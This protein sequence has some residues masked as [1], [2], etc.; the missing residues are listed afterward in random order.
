VAL[1]TSGLINPDDNPGAFDWQSE[2]WDRDTLVVGHLPFM[3]RLVSH[4]LIENENK[5]VTAY[6]PGSIVCLE[7]ADNAHWQIDW[8]IR[9]ALLG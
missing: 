1:E 6:E 5:P 9:P 3:A 8:M 7:S 2:S 4:L